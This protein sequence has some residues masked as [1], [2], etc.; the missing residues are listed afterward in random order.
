MCSTL[1]STCTYCGKSDILWNDWWATPACW[2]CT[3]PR[4]SR[5]A[6]PVW[7]GIRP[8]FLRVLLERCLGYVALLVGFIV[9]RRDTIP[10]EVI[11]GLRSSMITFIIYN[12]AFAFMLSFIDWA[13]HAGGF[14]YGIVC[15]MIL[16]QP[17]VNDSVRTRWIRNTLL[18]VVS[19]II[20]SGAFWLLPSDVPDIIHLYDQ[21]AQR[22]EMPRYKPM[23]Y[24][25]STI[26]RR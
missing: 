1:A 7:P 23:T 2:C 8:L 26:A 14:V 24:F 15:G 4:E 19:A 6:S 18:A 16:S 12:A 25:S 11:K 10:M 22:P 5:P 20:L 17:V 21:R 13:A 3:S 9:L